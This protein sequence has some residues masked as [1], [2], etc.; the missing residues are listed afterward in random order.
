VTTLIVP[1]LDEEPWPTMGPQIV[2]FLRERSIFGP[3]SLKGQPYEPDVE[4][5]GWLYRAYEVHPQTIR[6]KI[7]GGRGDVSIDPNP[8]AGR[9]RFKRCG[10]SVR[11]GLGKTERLAQIAYGE[12]HAEGPVRADGF[13]AYG[14]PVG[15]PVRDPYIPL[16]AVQAKQVEELGYGALKVICEDG[17]DADMFDVSL[18]RII[19]LDEYGRADGKA[20]P[21]ANNPGAN[22][23]ARTT[24]QGFDEPHRLILQ[25][26]HD[27]HETMVANLEKRALEDPWGCYVGTAGN[28]GEESIAEGLHEEALAIARGEVAEPQLFYM[29]REAGPGYDMA[30]L[31]QRVAAVKDAT[32]PLPEYGPGQFRSIALQW[33]RRGADKAYLERVWTNRWVKSAQ[34]AFDPTLFAELRTPN[35]IPAGAFVSAG[36]DGA[37]FRDSTAI[38]LTDIATGVQE[39]FAAWER[40]RDLDD[41]AQWEVPEGEVTQAW[42]EI[43]RRYK[44]WRCYG[45]PPHW[46]ETFGSW[47]GRWP[48]QF[49]E[50]WTNRTGYMARAIRAFK[51]A[52]DSHAVK[53]YWAEGDGRA[54]AFESHMANAGRK[55]LRYEDDDG[56]PLFILQKIA[57][58]RK[59][60]IAMA[61]CLSWTARLVAV[62]TNAQPPAESFVPYRIR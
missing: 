39:L 35:R 29:H 41:D 19:R 2:E 50:W 51:E 11:K 38:V 62:K 53:H 27:A 49:E 40:P 42:E 1:P 18:D 24:F 55:N 43:R 59:F 22:D 26:Q 61:A 5:T 30:D 45:D 56:T 25:R 58:D 60:D 46:T 6:R 32:G 37:R 14:E 16:L 52:Q 4:F 13:D 23:G 15:R 33:D 44:L 34:Q 8:F 28:L 54:I 36:F 17:P 10:M 3:G 47:A 57:P 48:D 21:L 7:P 12:L 20:V 9:R 31:E